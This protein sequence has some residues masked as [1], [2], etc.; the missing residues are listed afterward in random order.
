[1]FIRQ[2]NI[3]KSG[4]MRLNWLNISAKPIIMPSVTSIHGYISL[5]ALPF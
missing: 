2:A 5:M 4:N 1:M 3:A